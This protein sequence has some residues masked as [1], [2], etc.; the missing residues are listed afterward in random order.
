MP[1]SY[2]V[3]YRQISIG[4]RQEHGRID[5]GI[6]LPSRHVGLDGARGTIRQADVV[7]SR[8]RDVQLRKPTRRAQAGR[9]VR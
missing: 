4:E 6:K 5:G 1:R 7:Q 3:T 2:G 9:Q 8:V